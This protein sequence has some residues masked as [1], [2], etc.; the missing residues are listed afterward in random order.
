MNCPS[1]E[2]DSA[3]EILY[4]SFNQTSTALSVGS[5]NGYMLYDLDQVHECQPTYESRN[6]EDVCIIERNFSTSLVAYVS[7]HSPRNL[8][9]YNYNKGTEILEKLFPNTVLSVKL[10]RKNVV[11]CLEDKIYILYIMGLK[12][13]KLHAITNTPSNVKGLITLT[14]G[15]GNSLLAYPGSCVNGNVQIFDATERHAKTT[16]PAHTSP[17]AALAFD[18]DGEKLATASIK[19]TVIRVFSIVHSQIL[20]EFRRGVKR[21]VEIQSLSFNIGSEFLCASSNTE[22]V[23]IF[24]LSAD[25]ETVENIDEEGWMEMFGRV[26]TQSAKYLPTQMSDVLTQQ[27]AFATVHLPSIGQKTVS[28]ITKIQNINYVMIASLEGFLYIYELNTET[29]GPCHLVKQ[30]RFR[31]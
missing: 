10:N 18:E 26:L 16:I 3:R 4:L 1:E 8:V 13:E 31:K 5:K 6:I 23:H 7:L 9:L 24:K 28:A 17:L 19:G 12:D 15:N 30:H 14:Y 22:T 25:E 11:V 29:G 27:R 2:A 21:C 20:F